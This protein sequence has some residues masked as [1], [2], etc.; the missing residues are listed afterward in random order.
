[1]S[2]KIKEQK[3]NK[4]K[5]INVKRIL[6]SVLAGVLGFVLI[7]ASVNSATVAD[8]IEKAKSYSQVAI[9]DQLVPEKDENGDWIFVYH[10]RDEICFNGKCGYS[11]CDPLYDP[12]RSARIR[13]VKWSSDGLPI[14]NS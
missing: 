3:M 11:D 4:S 5:K 8:K 10:S 6:L 14:L 13:K 12:C 9:E 7:V 1:M 2:V